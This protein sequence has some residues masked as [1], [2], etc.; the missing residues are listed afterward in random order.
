[1]RTSSATRA[2]CFT[3]WDD[4]TEDTADAVQSPEVTV[5]RWAAVVEYDGS[6]YNGW[7]RQKHSMTVQQKVEQALSRVANEPVTL[8]CAGRT[9]SGVHA[10]NQVIHF[11]SVAERQPRNW[12]LGVNANLPADIRLRWVGPVA[13]DFSA[14]FSALKRTYRYIICN[15][16][17]PPA[18]FQRNVTWVADPLDDAAMHRAG[19]QL[20]GERDFSS[21]RAAGCQ[22]NTPFRCVERL[23]VRRAGELVVVEICANA[24]L[25]HMVRNIV[26]ALL[27]VGRGMHSEPWL[28][29]LL[30]CR[31][32]TLAPP[33]AP[34]NGLYLVGVE[35][36][37]ASGV[38]ALP[39]GP[40][41]LAG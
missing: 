13:V 38:A 20:L 29:E 28:G 35:Y 26:G 15:S 17:H 8:V 5:Q 19:Q 10:T 39:F 23:E 31:D 27:A 40:L 24:F 1:M 7:Q 12:L 18:L 3:H 36:P 37:P 16:V 14:R 33:T 11:D 6:A 41:L 22:S 30:E 34:A 32:R 21:F 9:D 2:S 25:H 4:M